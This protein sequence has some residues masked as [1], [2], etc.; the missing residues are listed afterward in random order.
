MST[1]ESVVPEPHEVVAIDY[2]LRVGAGRILTRYHIYRP[3]LNKESLMI[4]LKIQRAN[5]PCC[6][7]AG[8]V[9]GDMLQPSGGS[10]GSFSGSLR[11]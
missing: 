3:L 9:T 8:P 6:G 1:E 5:T 7:T 2:L 10:L 11:K 4:L